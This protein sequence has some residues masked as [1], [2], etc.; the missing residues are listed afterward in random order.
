MITRDRSGRGGGVAILFRNSRME[1]K[2]Y[3]FKRKRYEMIAAK[4]TH[5]DVCFLCVY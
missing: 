4:G 2:E 3:R 1:M 5:T